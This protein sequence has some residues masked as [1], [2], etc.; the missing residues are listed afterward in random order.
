[1]KN[2]TTKTTLK[3]LPTRKQL[4]NIARANRARVAKAKALPKVQV[5]GDTLDEIHY[6]VECIRT[7]VQNGLLHD[8]LQATALSW[9]AIGIVVNLVAQTFYLYLLSAKH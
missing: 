8:K 1:M 6:S 9:I 3:P 7:A 4:L 2:T 5:T